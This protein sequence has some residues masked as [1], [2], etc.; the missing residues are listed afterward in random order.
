MPL[1]VAPP[2]TAA[3]LAPRILAALT[4]GPRTRFELRDRLGIAPSDKAANAAL[5][6]ALAALVADRRLFPLRDLF[7]IRKPEKEKEKMSK[8]YASDVVLNAALVAADQEAARVAVVETDEAVVAADREKAAARINTALGKLGLDVTITAADLNTDGGWEVVPG[9]ALDTDINDYL[10]RTNSRSREFRTL[11]ALGAAIRKHQDLARQRE[12]AEKHEQTRPQFDLA[13]RVFGAPGQGIIF[14]PD[15]SRLALRPFA[16][17][18]SDGSGPGQALD[19]SSIPPAAAR[20]LADAITP[21]EQQRKTCL[22]ALGYD[23]WGAARA[24]GVAFLVGDAS[25]T[26]NLDL[27]RVERGEFAEALRA[28]ADYADAL[29][30]WRE[31]AS[32]LAPDLFLEPPF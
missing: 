29:A 5:S 19:I 9:L 7:I 3:E 18:S 14:S 11:A 4:P 32:A 24:D 22:V 15:D 10:R 6:E 12:A 2:A 21:S 31:A 30:A 23:D 17:R 28:W 1:T 13:P 16:A 20:A 26:I 27:M 25:L 8:Q